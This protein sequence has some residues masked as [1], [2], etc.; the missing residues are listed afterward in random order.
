VELG[1][2]GIPP[3][4]RTIP[5]VLPL[6]ADLLSG[7]DAPTQNGSQPVVGDSRV[8]STEQFS[9]LAERRMLHE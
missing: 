2:A 5:I 4:F 3:P 9:G 7:A 8:V 1:R 6:S